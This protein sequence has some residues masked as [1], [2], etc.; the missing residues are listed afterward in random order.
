[1]SSP[2]EEMGAQLEDLHNRWPQHIM[3]F[4]NDKNLGFVRTVN[5]GIQ[6]FPECDVVLLNSDVVLP[7]R[8]LVRLRDDAYS[9]PNI[10]T[11][12]PLSNNTTICTFPDF[13]EE[14]ELPYGLNTQQVDHSFSEFHLP[15][16]A[17]PTGIGFCM[18]IRRDALN[19]VGKFDA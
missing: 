7:S 14:N 11:V 18:Y 8:W 17:A 2:E 10:A 13:L 4:T 15:C 1:D 16:V 19:K 9:G 6:R 3:V 12:T 5:L